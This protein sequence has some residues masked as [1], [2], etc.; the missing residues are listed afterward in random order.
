MSERW[1]LFRTSPHAGVLM[2]AALFAF[3]SGCEKPLDPRIVDFRKTFEAATVPAGETPVPEARKAAKVVQP[4]AP[5][6]V[7]VRGRINAGESPPWESG[8]SAFV[9]TD[10]AGHDGD[11]SHNPHTCPFCSRNIQDLLVRVEFTDKSG[12]LIPLD[13]RELLNVTEFQLVVV[14]GMGMINESDILVLNATQIYV[15]R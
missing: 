9:I 8:K 5:V 12:Q 4:P 6:K 7:V 15:K 13:A 1:T 14:E 11:E 10:A 2:M 3:I